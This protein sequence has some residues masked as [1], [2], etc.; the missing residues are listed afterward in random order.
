MNDSQANLWSAKQ[1]AELYGIDEW[2]S[3]Y[4]GISDNGNVE[5][6]AQGDHGQV[7]VPLTDIIDG[8]SQRGLQMPVLLR[9]ENLVDSRL[10]ILNESFAHAIATTG[11]QGQYRGAF[12]IK[13][14]QQSHI[15]E[16]IARFGERYNH[17]LEA[18][19]KAELMIAMSVLQNR[20]SLIICNGYKDAEFIDLGLQARKLGFKCIF[21][22]ET[23]AEVKLVIE[24]SRAL[25]V[26]PIIG[27]RL[28]LSTKV[29]GHWA[30]DSGDRSLFGLTTKELVEIIDLLRAAELI[31]SLQLLHFHLGSQIPN[32]RNIRA[33][34][35][36][37]CRYYIEMVGEGAPLSYID[38]GGG[39]AIDYDGTS[40]VSG[41]SRNYSVEEYCVDVVE[42]IAQQLDAHELPHPTIVTESGRATVAHTSVLLFNVLDVGHFNPGPIPEQ[43]PEKLHE[44]I[45]NLWYTVKGVK[46]EKLQ[47]C[48]NDVIYYRD[49]VRDCFFSGEI[50][51]RDRAFA[52]NLCLVGLQKIVEL[53]PQMKRIPP[54][55][56]ELPEQLAD[57]YYGNFSVF[58]SLPDSWAIN[59][60]FPVMPIHR[61][62]E[63]PSRQATIA[64]LTCDCDGKLDK[65]AGPEGETNTVSLHPINPDEEYYLGVF[66]VGA[67][68][69]TL[70]DLHNL[71]GDT[72]VASVRINGDGSLDFVH[73][74]HGDSISDVLSYVEYDPQSM[75]R[76]FRMAAEQAVRD[77]RITVSDRQQMLAAYSESLRGYTYFER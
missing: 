63:K 7:A 17:G 42:A 58:Q 73:E 61:L 22:L 23:V 3:G 33:G 54:E 12:P 38:L 50:N 66:L 11:Y 52:E 30:E 56:E 57:I 20:E 39:L 25:D 71:F 26:D 59:Q 49:Q 36:E 67:Y 5:V 27:V 21:V 46:L 60:V 77:G 62:D 76:Q 9:I 1:S 24:R 28:K 70:G 18:G 34:V 45:S 19:S 64:D 8:L 2:G 31:H 6:R 48:Y 32:I 72:N 4:F 51:L 68:Q 29:D 55:L 41:H 14:N 10:S 16:E 75:F 65:F 15:V 53:I 43:L 35:L 47:E 13:V 37:A 44:Q 69:E 40:S 74:L